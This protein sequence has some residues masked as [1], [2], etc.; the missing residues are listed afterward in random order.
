MCQDIPVSIAAQASR[1]IRE[2]L[3]GGSNYGSL[4]CPTHFT[5]EP[6]VRPPLS[7]ILV[8]VWL[9]A[10]K[11][12]Y[13]QSINE[14]LQVCVVLLSELLHCETRICS[15]M[16]RRLLLYQRLLSFVYIKPQNGAPLAPV[17][18]F[19]LQIVMLV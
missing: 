10:W 8:L 1:P 17:L 2:K 7:L 15:R 5:T 4:L 13:L 19:P 14:P 12:C 11:S 6:S 16:K 18:F 3:N 9:W